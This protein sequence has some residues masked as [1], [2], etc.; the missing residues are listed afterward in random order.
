MKT[1][2]RTRCRQRKSL[3]NDSSTRGIGLR[4]IAGRVALLDGSLTITCPEKGGTRIL[5]RF[6]LA[7]VGQTGKYV[8]NASRPAQLTDLETDG[9][10]PAFYG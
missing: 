10:Q 9:G 2:C 5:I 4:S 7:T 1:V 3:R 8:P 6:P